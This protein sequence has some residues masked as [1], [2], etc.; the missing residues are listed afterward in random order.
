MGLRTWLGR[1][2][3]PPVTQQHF[4]RA[5]AEQKEAIRELGIKVEQGNERVVAAVQEFDAEILGLVS[6]MKEA[7]SEVS[8]DI[9]VHD[10]ARSSDAVGSAPPE[11]DP[12]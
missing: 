8:D 9:R 7:L 2:F 10:E 6:E 4:D 1:I 5:M 12:D 11:D 3:D